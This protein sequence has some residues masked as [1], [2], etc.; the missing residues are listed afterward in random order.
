MIPCFAVVHI[1]NP[2]HHSYRVWLPL[3]LVWLL[4]L[5]LSPFFLLAL[6]VFS[7]VRHVAFFRAIAV[8][9]NIFAALPGTQVDLSGGAQN[10]HI[11]IL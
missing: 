5:P 9:W 3:F 6:C 2:Y 10:V 1:Q 7:F 4:L 8:L 11:R